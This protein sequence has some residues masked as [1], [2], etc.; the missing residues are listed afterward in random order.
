MNKAEY[1]YRMGKKDGERVLR[2]G[3]TETRGTEALDVQLSLPPSKSSLDEPGNKQGTLEYSQ[4]WCYRNSRN[5][6]GISSEQ[7]GL[8]HKNLQEISSCNI[9]NF[10]NITKI[11]I[12]RSLTVIFWSQQKS[13]AVINSFI[14]ARVIIMNCRNG[15]C[16][17]NSS[18]RPAAAS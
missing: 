2:A 3:V 16:I 15:C 1:I 5:H 12:F 9:F 11:F 17:R 18:Y 7:R 13:S 14:N 4:R 6:G 8:F 10:E